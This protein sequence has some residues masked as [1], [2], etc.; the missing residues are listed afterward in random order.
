MNDP[1]DDNTKG[2]AGIEDETALSVKYENP[3]PSS[4]TDSLIDW[5]ALCDFEPAQ[6]TVLPLLNVKGESVAAVSKFDL[7]QTKIERRIT[8]KM[9][10]LI[11][12]VQEVMDSLEAH[13]THFEGGI[14]R[15][16]LHNH[17]RRLENQK[18]VEKSA[19]KAQSLFLGLLHGLSHSST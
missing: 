19:K 11:Q 5:T 16:M 17:R 4:E 8:R 9:E 10:V 14:E 6:K 13:Y 1:I 18:R 2:L 15:I 12:K 3:L 7:V